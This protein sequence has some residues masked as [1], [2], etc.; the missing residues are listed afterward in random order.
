[1]EDEEIPLNYF[2]AAI[3]KTRWKFD[4]HFDEPIRLLNHYGSPVLETQSCWES[5]HRESSYHHQQQT[6]EDLRV[7]YFGNLAKALVIV[8]IFDG[9]EMGEKPHDFYDM[10]LLRLQE[11]KNRGY[12]KLGI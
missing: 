6:F 2:P 11:F 10:H 1:M 9:A 8:S 5:H 7:G 3:P 4:E 12:E